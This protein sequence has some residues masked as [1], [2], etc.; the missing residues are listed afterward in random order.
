MHH[1]MAFCSTGDTV[2]GM[3]SHRVRHGFTL[4]EIA[5]ALVLLGTLLLIALPALSSFI[6]KERQTSAANSLVAAQVSGRTLV[7]DS[8]YQFPTDFEDRLVARDSSFTAGA[9]TGELVSV[10]SSGPTVA[11]YATLTPSGACV[12][13]ADFID[14]EV[15]GWAIDETPTSCEAS[16]LDGSET[17]ANGVANAPA[18]IDLGA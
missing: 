16:I 18:V 2:Q 8:G 15:R 9:A 12:L 11:V 4:F 14:I 17:L 10:S 6:G 7:L 3:T 1:L 5:A 13:M